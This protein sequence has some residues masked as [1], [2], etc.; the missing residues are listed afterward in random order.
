MCEDVR[1]FSFS[2]SLVEIPAR[3]GFALMEAIKNSQPHLGTPLGAAVK[4]A[5]AGDRPIVVTDEQSQD[6]VH[7]DAGPEPALLEIAEASPGLV[8]LAIEKARLGVEV[9]GQHDGALLAIRPPVAHG[10][11]P[12]GGAPLERCPAAAYTSPRRI[13][14]TMTATEGA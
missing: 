7:P 5:P 1:I 3:R 10:M 13:A 11:S 2:N 6:P 14:G 12:L 8:R 4:N 9:E